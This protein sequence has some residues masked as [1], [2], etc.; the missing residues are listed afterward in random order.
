MR[1]LLTIILSGIFYTAALGQEKENLNPSLMERSMN[2]EYYMMKDKEVWHYQDSLSKQLTEDVILNDGTII[3]P[4]GDI[5]L[6]NGKRKT[7]SNGQ[8]VDLSAKV[9][10]CENVRPPKKE[11]SAKKT[12]LK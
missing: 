12:E 6:K 3:T 10:N 4:N 9:M 2:H 5:I 1:H 7:L 8:C 11:E